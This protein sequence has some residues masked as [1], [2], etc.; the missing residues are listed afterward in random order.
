MSVLQDRYELIYTW[1]AAGVLADGLYFLLRP[2]MLS[3]AR[4]RW[5]ALLVPTILFSIYFLTLYV[6][7]GLH[8]R[9]H[10]WGG[11]IVLAGV[12]G[13]FLSYLLVPPKTPG[14]KIE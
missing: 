10:V 12:A 6:T 9:I 7:H 5:F 14:D 3:P 13:V 8:W 1:L 11:G 4:L 2:G